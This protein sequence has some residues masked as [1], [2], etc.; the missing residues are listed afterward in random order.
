MRRLMESDGGMG[1]I[2]GH[3]VYLSIPDQS[4]LHRFLSL[5]SHI[6]IR[7]PINNQIGDQF[8]HSS[9]VHR[10]GMATPKLK[11]ALLSGRVFCESLTG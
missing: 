2:L 3:V 10:P 11:W 9:A 6:L 1:L 8:S 4:Q 7:K 5:C